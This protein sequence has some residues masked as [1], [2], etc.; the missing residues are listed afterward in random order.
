MKGVKSIQ[1]RQ[2]DHGRQRIQTAHDGIHCV[3]LELFS[4]FVCGRSLKDYKGIREIMEN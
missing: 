3:I 1:Q 4:C 2:H